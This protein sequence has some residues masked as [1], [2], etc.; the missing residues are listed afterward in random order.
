MRVIVPYALSILS[1]TVPETDAPEWSSATAYTTGQQVQVTS[2]AGAP[3]RVYQATANNTNKYPP[4]NPTEWSE[5]GPTNRWAMVDG[6]V[7]TRTVKDGGFSCEIGYSGTPDTL[8]ILGLSG[9]S[10]VAY[11]QKDSGGTQV[12]S[13]TLSTA[14]PYYTDWKDW[15]FGPNKRRTELVANIG[16]WPGSLELDFLGT[17]GVDAEVGMALVGMQRQVGTSRYGVRS[18]ITDYSRKSTNDFGQT[19]LK[20]GSYA[21]RLELSAFVESDSRQT[22]FRTLADLRATPCFWM[23]GG[24]GEDESVQAYGWL[25]DWSVV[26]E[27]P[28]VTEVSIEIEGLI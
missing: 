16:L 12:A 11:T 10:S 9:V 22:A 27:G 4:D 26:V 3:H 24:H 5:V 19:Y 13:G 6:I 7:E 15:L 25:K 1:S 2:G 28:A 17:A 21:K 18:G 23:A 20:K 8:V 14:S